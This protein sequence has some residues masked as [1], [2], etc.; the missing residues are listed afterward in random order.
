MKTSFN[1]LLV[2]TAFLSGSILRAVDFAEFYS[3]PKKVDLLTYLADTVTMTERLA[4]GD[5][6]VDA[7]EMRNR[8]EQIY[9]FYMLRFA[10]EIERKVVGN[11]E[12]AA[13]SSMSGYPTT[14]LR[15]ALNAISRK[16][17]N[18]YKESL[19]LMASIHRSAEP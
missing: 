2:V 13:G 6:K 12:K 15:F 10:P 19:D 8:I 11:L 16:R 18:S 14:E 3:E 17:G 1:L 5:K 4:A 7:V 9:D